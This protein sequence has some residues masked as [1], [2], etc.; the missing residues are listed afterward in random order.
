MI[1]SSESIHTCENLPLLDIQPSQGRINLGIRELWKC[2]ELLYF[3]TW[4]EIKVRYKQTAL[5]AAWAIIQPLFSML[6]FSLFFGRLGRIPS[7][8]VPYPLFV[9]AGLVPWMFFSNALSNSSNSLVNSAHLIT[10][11]YFPRLALP[12]ASVLAGTVDFAISFLLLLVLMAHYG[13]F[14]AARALLL[15]LFFLLSIVTALG[16]GFWLSALNVEFRDIK[17]TVPFIVQMWLFAT[18]IIY[19]SSLLPGRWWA[20]YALNPMAGVVEGFRWALLGSGQQP[21]AMMFVSALVAV[22]LLFS[23]AYYFRR[24]ERTFADI[25]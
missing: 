24:M 17:Y 21:K 3:L 1:R 4:R 23:G 5:G 25:V 6:I 20:L 19:P 16:V 13:V 10:K 14:P 2:R 15:P 8:G 7:D 22:C 9:L 12:I 11:V 18:P